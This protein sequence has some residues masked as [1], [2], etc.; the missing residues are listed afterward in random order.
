MLPSLLLVDDDLGL[1]Q[2]LTLSL[3]PDY[4]VKAVHS[5]QAALAHL[6][7][8]KVDCVLLD[9]GLPDCD[10]LKLIK[11]MRRLVP[12]MVIIMVTGADE[13][14]DVVRAVKLGAFAYLAKP[15]NLPLL[16]RHIKEGLKQQAESVAS[17][18]APGAEA[19]AAP[20]PLLYESKPLAQALA[21]A[22][23]VVERG[24]TPILI[25]GETGTGKGVLARAIHARS[26]ARHEPFVTVNCAALSRELVESELFGYGRGAF[27]GAR[28]EGRKGR[29]AQAGSG[30]IFLDEIGAMPL[31]SQAK[32]LSVVEDRFFCPV[33]GDAEIPVAA[34]VIAATNVDLSE[35]VARGT[36][37]QDLFY[38]L[39]PIT[40]EIPPLR[41]ERENILPLARHFLMVFRNLCQSSF[42]AISPEAEA[43]LRA[44]SWP[45]NV[46]ELRNT[47]ERIALLEE[48]EKIE[49]RHLFLGGP[50]PGLRPLPEAAD[51]DSA[52]RALIRER[53]KQ[54]GGNVAQAARSLKMAPHKLRYRIKQ[55]GL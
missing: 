48:G 9:I 15:V 42:T 34:R 20:A 19:S 44:H 37:R 33:G 27:T 24:P 31:E 23:R 16:R 45:G 25:C 51:F 21:L 7:Q 5:G 4:T 55:L 40:L 29:F 26:R 53:L 22:A 54:N 13:I 39:N 8:E 41:K 32:L 46:R 14:D 12:E 43:R 28:R 47:I 6:Q 1:T 30:T 36:F 10:G 3:A 18:P 11:A 17:A 50:P 38:R 2:A 52:I 35:A 49:P